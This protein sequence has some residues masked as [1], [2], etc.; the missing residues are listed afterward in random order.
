MLLRAPRA[1]DVL[2]LRLLR[3][4]MHT[5]KNGDKYAGE[6]VADRRQGQGSRPAPARTE[7]RELGKLY[8][9]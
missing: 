5:W 6:F 3:A 4:G 8:S 1:A 2:L 7:M 9:R